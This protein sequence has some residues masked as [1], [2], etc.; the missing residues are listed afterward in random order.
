MNDDQ[1]SFLRSLVETTGPS[2]FEQRAQ[3]VWINRVRDVAEDVKVDH[4]GNAIASINRD[5]NP[6]VMIEAHID[7]I[8]FIVKYIDDDGFV[9]FA[10]I[11]GFDASTLAGNRV[12]IEG[13]NGPVLG[14]IGRK[15][16]HLI[17]P[18]ERKQAPNIKNMWIDIGASSK[19]E[20]ESL[21]GIGDAGGRRT[22]VERLRGS[23]I[24]GNS[25][26][27][28]VCCYIIAEVFR[29]LA[30]ST[31]AAGVYAVSAVQEEIGLRGARV[32][33]YEVNPQIGIALDVIWTSDHPHSSRTELGEITTGKG[34][35]ITRGA[36]TNPRVYQRLIEA[37]RGE[38][39]PYQI[40]A[41]PSATHTDEDVMQLARGGVATGLISVPTRYLHT[42]SEVLSTDDVD[43][44]VRIL[45]RFVQD[46]DG[47][48]DL[49]P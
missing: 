43:A 45:T 16:T 37:A 31:P 27:D 7:E 11:G 40:E 46:L 23:L 1:F 14:V 5:G 36:S 9:Y 35:V 20:A 10:P 34:P 29:A 15:P 13:A 22:G 6:R 47:P 41:A 18:E 21:V 4:M 12:S 49:T 3:K 32:A 33:A 48:V 2:G 17:D 42:A 25:F 39:V 8:G 38:G 44:A 24:T 30:Q 28:R 26:D 19:Q